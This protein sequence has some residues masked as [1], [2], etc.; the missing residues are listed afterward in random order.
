MSPLMFNGQNV[1]L[2]AEGFLADPSQWSQA[3]HRVLRQAATFL[4]EM[5]ANSMSR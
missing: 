2:N 3:R 5:T 4:V 1:E